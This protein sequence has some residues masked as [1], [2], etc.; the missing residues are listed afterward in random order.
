MSKISEYQKEK[1]TRKEAYEKV[2]RLDGLVTLDDCKL[3]VEHN[4]AILEF[5][6]FA[7]KTE[8]I[9]LKA[10][11]NNNFN[12]NLIQYIPSEM[13]TKDFLLSVVGISGVAL[14]YIPLELIDVDIICNAVTQ[15]KS[16]IQY[17]PKEYETDEIFIKILEIYPE[18][19]EYIID[20]KPLLF[21]YMNNNSNLSLGLMEKVVS[22]K[23][24]NL[25]YIPAEF[26]TKE[27]CDFSFNIS[28]KSFQF[29]PDKY[30]TREMCEFVTG[31]SILFV[32]YCPIWFLTNE[33][34]EAFIRKKRSL[35]CIP[36]ELRTEKLCLLAIQNDYQE[37]QSIPKNF[38][39]E[40]FCIKSLRVNEKII[41]FIPKELK[42]F[43]V[44]KIIIEKVSFS[45]YFIE[46]LKNI[47]SKSYYSYS[48]EYMIFN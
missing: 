24:G 35:R 25:K 44:Y 39:T 40:E 47:E 8:E 48:E 5:V 1:Q 33:M 46:W 19:L 42:T 41:K 23:W 45:N 13:L 18:K 31:K 2:K 36:N 34:C 26:I 22:A 27:I 10:F 28:W 9:C 17:I 4:G 43:E 7:F 14:K 3:A 30:K 12:R 21:E 11:A 6:P 37:F 20:K 32:E 16:A 38:L 29:F 15:N